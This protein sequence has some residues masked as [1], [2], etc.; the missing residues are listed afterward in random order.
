[1][2]TDGLKKVTGQLIEYN[3]KASDF[4]NLYREKDEQGDFFKEVKP[5]ADKVFELCKEWEQLANG[6]IAENKPKHL[7][8]LQIKNTSENLQTVSIRC[9]FPD[10]SL[11]KFNSHIQSNQYVL[12]RLLDALKENTI[13]EN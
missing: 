5:F 4:F 2:D 6:W 11:K 1:M 3:E 12:E 7:H 8:R 13:P 10:S 9:F